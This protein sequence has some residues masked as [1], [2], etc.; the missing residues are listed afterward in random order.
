PEIDI[1]GHSRAAIKALPHLLVEAEDQSD[2]C[3]VQMYKDN[4]LNP[5][6]AGTYEFLY[7]VMDEVCDLFP[8]PY[9]HIGADEVP[10]TVWQKSPACLA[11]AAEEGYENVK[12]LQGH[13]LC[14]LQD[15]LTTKGRILMGWEEAGQ[16]AKLDHSA[17]ICAWTSSDSAKEIADSGYKVIACAAPYT[18]LDLAWDDDL[19]EPGF[20]WA[21][22]ANLKLC[23]AYEPSDAKNALYSS[24]FLGVQALL[25]SE[26]ITTQEKL[27]YML[28]PR[29]LAIAETAWTNKDRKDWAHFKSRVSHQIKQLALQGVT[30]RSKLDF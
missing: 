11:L 4:V 19:N 5:A 12:A 29:L 10:D 14:K 17:I 28:L 20:Q 3:S 30:P 16:G 21:G 8:S 27:E 22:T 1:P 6:L 2:Y 24:Q 13:L 18:Y 26:L 15:Y 7:A 25:W 9:V 23:Y